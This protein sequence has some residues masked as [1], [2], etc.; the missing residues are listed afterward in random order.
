MTQNSASP[1]VVLAGT[2]CPDCCNTAGW[3]LQ[4]QT[5]HSLT[6]TTQQVQAACRACGNKVS[7]VIRQSSA[8]GRIIDRIRFVLGA[9]RDHHRTGA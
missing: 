8:I 2:P 1:I 5:I 7:R 9:S 4:S 3:Q 6:E